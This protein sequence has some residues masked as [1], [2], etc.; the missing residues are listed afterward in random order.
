MKEYKPTNKIIL[1]GGKEIYLTT[2][3]MM[4]VSQ[5]YRRLCLRDYIEELHPEWEERKVQAV[6]TLTYARLLNVGNSE[7]ENA[8]IELSAKAWDE[9]EVSAKEYDGEVAG[10]AV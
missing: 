8:A 3:E 7:E 2:D 10:Y 5:V 6:A 9:I 4:V 1:P